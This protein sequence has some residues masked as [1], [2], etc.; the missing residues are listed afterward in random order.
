MSDLVPM[1]N[2]AQFGAEVENGSGVVLVDFFADW[3]GPC[4][5]IAPVLE[6]LAEE[7]EA[8]L[9]IV[10]INADEEGDILA[11]YAVRGLPTM[12]VFK[13]GQSVDVTVGA[14]PYP[15]IKAMLEKHL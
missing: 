3:C 13:D 6:Q 7:Y 11:K 15:A 12:M 2:A 1:I 9:K 8:K 5:M 4:K 10:K 14:Q